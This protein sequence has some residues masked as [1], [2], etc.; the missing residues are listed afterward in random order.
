VKKA[1]NVIQEVKNVV[2]NWEK[3]AKILGI[4][5]VEIEFKANAFRMA[6]IE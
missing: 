5:T 4:S 2:Q 1:K 3:E 6:F